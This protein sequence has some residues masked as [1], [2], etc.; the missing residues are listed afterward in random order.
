ME[1]S[2]GQNLDSSPA[3]LLTRQLTAPLGL[4]S[5]SRMGTI[6]LPAQAQSL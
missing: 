4:V 1:G 3:L 2:H 5:L 6:G